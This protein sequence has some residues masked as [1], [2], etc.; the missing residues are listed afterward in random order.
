MSPINK[1]KLIEVDIISK[2][3]LS[4]VK[5]AD[6]D[7]HPQIRLEV[8]LRDLRLWCVVSWRLARG[9]VRRHRT[10]SIMRLLLAVIEAK[11]NKHKLGKGMWLGFDCIRLL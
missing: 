3:L 4:A 1:A 7:D 11:A 10:Q 9:Q 5:S 6:W 2:L 8:K